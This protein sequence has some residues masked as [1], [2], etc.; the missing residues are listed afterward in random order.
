MGRRSPD[1]LAEAWTNR[2]LQAHR[3][4]SHGGGFDRRC[5]SVMIVPQ[6]LRL[7]FTPVSYKCN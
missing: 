1:P 7:S 3:C 5:R 4:S 6:P 2:G